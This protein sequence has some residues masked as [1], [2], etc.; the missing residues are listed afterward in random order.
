MQEFK[1][2]EK[3]KVATKTANQEHTV[4]VK[5]DRIKAVASNG[6]SFV[7]LSNGNFVST[8]FVLFSMCVT[9]LTIGF[10]LQAQ[11][12]EDENKKK[13]KKKDNKGKK[14]KKKKTKTPTPPTSSS[15]SSS[16]DSSFNS[17][18][19]SD[20]S[21]PSLKKNSKKDSMRYKKKD[22]KGK[23]KKDKKRD[24]RVVVACKDSDSESD[25]SVEY[26]MGQKFQLKN[27]KYAKTPHTSTK[28]SL[29]LNPVSTDS[30]L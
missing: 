17:S 1:A 27:V 12:N 20:R 19:K 9:K 25:G 4:Q 11:C 14:A 29:S 16:S 23:K 24:K 18:S 2:K 5:Q 30:T 7:G 15:F 10:L 28:A 22:E 6:S 3:A 21:S 8:A 26:V 13:C